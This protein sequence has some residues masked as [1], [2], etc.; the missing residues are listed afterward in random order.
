MHTIILDMYCSSTDI[1]ALFSYSTSIN[2]IECIKNV[3]LLV[4]THTHNHFT[5]GLEYVRVHSGQQ[6]PER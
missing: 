2:V 3:K 4:H 5:A 1:N 6:V